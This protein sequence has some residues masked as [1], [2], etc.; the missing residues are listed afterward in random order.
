MQ[1]TQY[2]CSGGM[3][4]RDWDIGTKIAGGIPLPPLQGNS[5]QPFQNAITIPPATISAPPA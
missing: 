2:L 3:R 1:G 4:T 5:P